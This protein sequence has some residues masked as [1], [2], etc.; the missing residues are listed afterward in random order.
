MHAKP[1][2]IP[3]MLLPFFSFFFEAL[4]LFGTKPALFDRQR[5]IDVCQT[6]WVASP[7][8]FFESHRFQPKYDLDKGLKETIDL[9]KENNWI[10]K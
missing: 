3:E 2:V 10:K 1:L 8:E 5:V 6:S 4:A 9:C 7:K